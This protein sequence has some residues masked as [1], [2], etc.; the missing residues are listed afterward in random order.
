MAT[1]LFAGANPL[2]SWLSLRLGYHT[3]GCGF[4]AA[5]LLGM[6][7][8]LGFVIDHLFNLEYRTFSSI[9]VAGQ[10]SGAGLRARRGGMFGRYHRITRGVHAT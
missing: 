6:V 8:S 7:T 5:C 2:L 4:A 1:L 9:E 10:R 3:Y